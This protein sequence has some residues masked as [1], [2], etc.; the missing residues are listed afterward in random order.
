MSKTAD[1]T[2]EV[3]MIELCNQ[4]DSGFILDGTAGKP[5]EVQVRA[6][7]IHA[8]PEWGFRTKYE[9]NAKG[10]KI[11]KGIEEIQYIEGIDEISKEEQRKAGL[12]NADGIPNSGKA[13]II[14]NKGYRTVIN[15]GSERGLF[16]YLSE[17]FWNEDAPLR[18]AK[19]EKYFRIF[20]PDAETQVLNKNEK[21][22]AEAVLYCYSLTEEVGGKTIYQ[23][24]KIDGL[25]QMFQVASEYGS[26]DS[27]LRALIGMAKVNPVDFLNISKKMEQSTLILVQQAIDL[28]VIKIEKNAAMYVS[29]DKILISFG[30]GN[31]SHDKKL[32]MLA[33]HLFT[34]DGY[35]ACNE[36]KIEVEVAQEKQLTTK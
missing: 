15:E 36:L 29:K 33:D 34:K 21:I 31:F 2:P 3:M 30:V 12:L 5:W 25:L 9:I 17:V 7:G 32:T 28:N 23:E 6:P 1:N 4:Q 24:E 27:K 11:A 18:S 35:E 10:E 22:K 19:A 20:R 13:R 8:I 14:V 16:K 26:P